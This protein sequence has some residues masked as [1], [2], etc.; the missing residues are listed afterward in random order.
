MLLRFSLVYSLQIILTITFYYN[1]SKLGLIIGS[2]SFMASLGIFYG[3]SVNWQ[4]RLVDKLIYIVCVVGILSDII[5]FYSANQIF[6]FLL[7]IFTLLTYLIYISIFRKE[8]SYF[9]LKTKKELPK[10]LAVMGS[11]FLFFG[12]VLKE[13]IPDTLYIVSIIYAL[14]ELVFIILSFYRP[15]TIQIS[16]FMVGFGAISKFIGDIFFSYHNFVDNHKIFIALNILFY[17][18]SQYLI[19]VG[20]LKNILENKPTLKHQIIED[21]RASKN[22]QVSFTKLYLKFLTVFYQ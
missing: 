2:G 19:I 20:L 10:I 6:Q 21:I 5:Q 22:Q 13:R 17:A 4:S 11:I 3:I 1:D 15:T 9:I 18:F 8:G 16:F 14:M 12:L 7:I